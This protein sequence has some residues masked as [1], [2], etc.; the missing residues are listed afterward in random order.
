MP[1]SPAGRGNNRAC[2]HTRS[3][4]TLIELLVVVTILSI[5]SLGVGLTASG[6]FGQRADPAALL[7]EAVERARDRAVL[8]QGLTGLVPR[9]DGWQ[10]R[11]RDAAG[12]WQ[13]MGPVAHPRG[14]AVRWQIDGRA[15][16]PG[17]SPSGTDQPPPIL[18][19]PDG[20]STPF[21]AALVSDRGR[22][23]CAAPRAGG[24]TCD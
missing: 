4:F 19:A 12:V 6:A 3:G 9:G 1:T 17:F 23:D 20:D 16:L 8:G 22:Q 24:L 18:F 7:S 15:A 2:G 11:L 10:L 14:L 21:A 13:D 5:L